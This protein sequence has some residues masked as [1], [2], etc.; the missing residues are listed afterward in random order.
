MNMHDKIE[1]TKRNIRTAI[2]DYWRH[3]CLGTEIQDDISNEFIEALAYD[4]VYAK[5]DLRSMQAI[6]VACYEGLAWH[7]QSRRL[8]LL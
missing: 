7:K 5:Q 8:R 1:L 4:S 2:S 6:C 3:T